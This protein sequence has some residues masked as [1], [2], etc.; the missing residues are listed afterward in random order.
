VQGRGEEVGII[1]V[2][3][4]LWVIIKYIGRKVNHL[5][6]NTYNSS[7]TKKVLAVN[8]FSPQLRF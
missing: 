4:L 5:T 3:R 1:V 7:G 8:L 6:G 2:R